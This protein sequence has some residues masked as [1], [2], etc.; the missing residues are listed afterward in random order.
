MLME[1][2]KITFGQTPTH[3]APHILP[4]SLGVG[5]GARIIS[6]I[7]TGGFLPANRENPPQSPE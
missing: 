2:K 4:L 1:T 7:S 6:H 3:L 5:C